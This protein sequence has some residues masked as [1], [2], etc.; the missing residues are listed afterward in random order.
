MLDIEAVLS[1][2]KAQ[3]EDPA[4]QAEQERKRIE[5]ERQDLAHARAHRV[6]HL[7]RMGIPL[8]VGMAA[9]VASIPRHFDPAECQCHRDVNSAKCVVPDG[10]VDTK[11]VALV[12]RWMETRRKQPKAWKPI[13][14]IL[15]GVG[16]GKTTAAAWACEWR[17]GMYTKTRTLTA[18]HRAMFGD[19]RE[20]WRS[21][22]R[23]PLL[24]IDDLGREAD[25]HGIVAVEDAIDERQ[26]HPTIITGNITKAEALSR[27][28]D[29]VS[30]RL[31]ES[32][33]VVW[34]DGEDRRQL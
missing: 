7:E 9:V 14:V 4:F 33:V 34:L 5:S 11:A 28:G 13:L 16:I 18:A 31:G 21:M 10:Y 24:V 19:Q 1:R 32:G 15:G 3:S 20:E 12:R 23:S 17:D 8:R 30:S 22:M 25:E 29:R 2:L 27:Y 26:S 6:R